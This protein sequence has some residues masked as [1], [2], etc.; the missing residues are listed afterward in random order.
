MNVHSFRDNNSKYQDHMD[1]SE[2]IPRIKASSLPL[3]DSLEEQVMLDP[4][5]SL[6][7]EAIG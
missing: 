6:P 4:S 7:K 2:C 3:M 5:N 1:T